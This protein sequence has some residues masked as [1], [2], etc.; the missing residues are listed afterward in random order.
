MYL[1]KFTLIAGFILLVA[2]CAVAKGNHH[3]N[4]SSKETNATII[5]PIGGNTW[6]SADKNGAAVDDNGL[7]KWRSKASVISTYIYAPKT[8]EITVSLNVKVPEGI[9]KIKVE[10]NGAS[11]ILEVKNHSYNIQKAGT[12]VLKKAGYFAVRLQ[13][14]SKTGKYFADVASVSIAG[15]PVAHGAVYTQNN[16]DNYFYWGRRGP[17]VHLNYK[18]PETVNQQI[19]WFYNEIT[20]PKGKD[21]IG[22]YFMANGFKEGYFGIQVNSPTERRIL[23]SVWSPFHTDD[24]KAIPDSMKIE[25]LKK[26]DNVKTGEFGNEGSGGQSYLVYNWEAGQTYRFLTHAKPV[27]KSHTIYTSYF[28]D[29]KKGKWLL[30]AS[31]KRPQTNTYLTRLHSFLENFDPEMGNVDRM[32]NYGNQWACDINGNWHE[33][34]NARFTGDQTARKGFRQDYAGGLSKD[35]NSFFLRNGGFFSEFVKLDEQFDRLSYKIKPEID[36]NK[37]P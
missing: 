31:F 16:D 15:T 21:P 9:S 3:A 27:D 14:I 23:F 25:L 7:S 26:G 4:H 17:S 12:F 13:G 5:V 8:G 20:V 30:I 36:F 29:P 22:S 35:H 32:A 37:L 33:L 10:V 6:I 34:T 18:V 2:G 11:K 1:K 24:P 28:F 19:E